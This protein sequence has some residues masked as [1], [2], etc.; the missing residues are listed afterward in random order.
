MFAD[1]NGARIHY[2]KE[3]SGPA[4]LM[5]HGGLVDTRSW[6]NQKVLARNFT[7]ITPDTRGF[8]QSTR[9]AGSLTMQDVVNDF[10]ELLRQLSIDSAY[11]LGFS[12]GGMFAQNLALSNPEL[13]KG[14]LLV[15]TRAAGFTMPPSKGGA[16]EVAAHV[17]RAYS[18]GFRNRSQEFLKGYIGMALENEQRGW[19]DVRATTTSGPDLEAIR[20][21]KCPTV[22]IHAR[23]DTA[24]PFEHAEA[25]HKAIPGARLEV[26]EESGHTMQIEKPELFNDLV[27]SIVLE[28]EGKKVAAPSA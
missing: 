7:L 5:I 2:E 28:W 13:V 6:T 17:N 12:I 4:L 3:G 9:P 21:I 20:A 15:S 14:L 8:G 10:A 22:I 1:I 24:V 26:V 18:E 23:G 16:E 27:R 19:D 25:M 11:V